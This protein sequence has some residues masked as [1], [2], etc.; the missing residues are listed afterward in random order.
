MILADTSIWIDHLRIC[1]P[2]MEAYLLKEQI[3]QHPF[4]AAEIALGSLKNRKRVLQ[5][6]DEIDSAEVA[7]LEEVRQMIEAHSLYSKGIGLTDA[8]LIA[9]CLLTPGTRLW[10]RDSNLTRVAQ[11]FGILFV[12]PVQ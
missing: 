7:N 9:S 10:T 2:V 3:I 5:D 11:W 8:H 6:L 12:P 1:N 4:V